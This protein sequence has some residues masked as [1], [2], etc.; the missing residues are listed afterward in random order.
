DCVDSTGAL[1]GHPNLTAVGPEAWRHYSWSFNHSAR[2][3]DGRDSSSPVN[4]KDV[5][6][7][8]VTIMSKPNVPKWSN[9]IPLWSVA[10]HPAI[11]VNIVTVPLWILKTVAPSVTK[12]SRGVNPAAADC[13]GAI[14]TYFS[15]QEPNPGIVANN[16]T[17]SSQ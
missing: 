15:R 4:L 14:V 9:V 3:R 13:D 12:T 7:W 2:G 16:E 1:V 11:V 17:V 5:A 6:S 8:H 10:M